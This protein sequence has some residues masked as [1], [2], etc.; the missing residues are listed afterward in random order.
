MPTQNYAELLQSGASET[1]R[2]RYLADG[3]RVAITL[4]IPQNLKAAAAEAAA[5][6]G[7]S[8]SALVRNCLINELTQAQG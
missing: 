3:D 4:R 8:F 6:K 2:R 7:M 5:L 1:E